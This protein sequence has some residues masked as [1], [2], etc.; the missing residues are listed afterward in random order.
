MF[1]TYLPASLTKNAGSGKLMAKAIGLEHRDYVRQYIIDFAIH[2]GIPALL[3]E[4]VLCKF[5][6]GYFRGHL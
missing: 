6:V 4:N 1:Q 3:Y 5:Y 2:H